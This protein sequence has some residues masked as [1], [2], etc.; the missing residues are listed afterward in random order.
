MD[1]LWYADRSPSG[2][3]VPQLSLGSGTAAACGLPLSALVPT[4]QEAEVR[5]GALRRGDAGGK[6]KE[7]GAKPV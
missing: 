3:C 1:V 2:R 7:C 6:V 4:E 5:Q